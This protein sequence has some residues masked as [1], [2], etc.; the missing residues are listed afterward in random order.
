[1]KI[2]KYFLMGAVAMSLFACSNDDE[3]LN[4]KGE[5]MTLIT[6][7]LGKAGNTRTLDGSAVGLCNK[8]KDLRFDFYT[9]DGRNLNVD[10]PTITQDDYK[11]LNDNHTVTISIGNVPVMAQK[12]SVLANVEHNKISNLDYSFLTKLE[13]SKV[14]LTKMVETNATELA[15]LTFNQQNSMMSGQSTVPSGANGE[16]VNVT[17]NLQPVSSRLQIEKFTAKQAPT[18]EEGQT[19]V[20]IENFDVKGIYI[21]QFYESGTINPDMNAAPASRTDKK[22]NKT[23]KNNYTGDKYSA[24]GYGFMGDDYTNGYPKT[25]ETF[26]V[27]SQES[28]TEGMIWEV[29]PTTKF[30]GYPVLAGVQEGDVFNSLTTPDVAHIVVELAVR[31]TTDEATAEPRKKYLTITGYKEGAESVMSFNRRHVYVIEDLTF[32]IYDLTDVPYE[33]DKTVS[34]TVNVLP[35]IEVTVTPEI[36]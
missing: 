10:Q 9:A 8:V 17:V 33:G 16:T 5:N 19:V 1:M 35:W 28:T 4:K 12:I 14:D 36:Q 13:N 15:T 21:N 26:D 25:G 18:P 11:N 31:Y 27:V 29:K 3:A 30:W 24:A 2:S 22:S 32:D 7:S 20:D 23:D 6:L 34:A